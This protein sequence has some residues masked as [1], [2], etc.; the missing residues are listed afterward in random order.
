M[1]K[2]KKELV[3][4]QALLENDRMKTGDSF[5]ELVSCDVGNVLADYFEFSGEPE[6]KIEKIGD[7]YIVN[8]T[9]ISTRVKNFEYVPKTL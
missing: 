9:L 7:K 8:I 3:R 5:F 1:K 2:D 6:I 4:L